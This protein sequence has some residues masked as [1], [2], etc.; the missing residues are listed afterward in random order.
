MKYKSCFIGL[1]L[2]TH[3]GL[4]NTICELGLMGRRCIYNGQLPHSIPY[5]NAD[6]IVESI[7]REFKSRNE[8]NTL[9]ANDMYD[10]LNIGDDWLYV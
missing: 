4:P 8:D 3:D 2:T 1:R 6:D 7:E 5:S 9:I 10:Y